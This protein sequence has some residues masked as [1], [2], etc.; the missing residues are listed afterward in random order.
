[1]KAVRKFLINALDVQQRLS[2][3]Q[4]SIGMGHKIVSYKYIRFSA[5]KK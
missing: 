1:M 3:T 2:T 4:L 5:E